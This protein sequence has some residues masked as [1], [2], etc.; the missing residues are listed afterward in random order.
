MGVTHAI[1]GQKSLERVSDRYGRAFEQFIWMELRAY[2]SYHSI[3][4]PLT[5]WRSVNKDEVD[6]LIGDEIAIE[7]K[8][9][10][11][12]HDKQLNG[13]FS[14][15]EEKRFKKLFLVSQDA[16]EQ[17]REGVHCLPWQKFLTELWSG[18]LI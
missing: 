1:L 16:S 9:S 12:I 13:L 14:L 7:V 18:N 3:L 17:K 5:F 8:A 10:Q 11:R 15:K 2:L 6:F 4:E